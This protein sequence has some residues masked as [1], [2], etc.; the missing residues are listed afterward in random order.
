[1]N[2]QVGPEKAGKI[3]GMLVDLET[4]SI[5]EIVETMHSHDQ[6]SSQIKEAMTLLD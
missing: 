3:T 6:L 5:R 4:Y 2:L 1:M